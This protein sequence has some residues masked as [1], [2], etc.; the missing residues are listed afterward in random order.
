MLVNPAYIQNYINTQDINTILRTPANIWETSFGGLVVPAGWTMSLGGSATVNYGLELSGCAVVTVPP[1][2]TWRLYRNDFTLSGA[3]SFT[4]RCTWA[5]QTNYSYIFCE[6]ADSTEQNQYYGG[7]IHSNKVRLESSTRDSG[8]YKYGRQSLD[9][10]PDSRPGFNGWVYLHMQCNSSMGWFCGI[11]R[12]G[13]TWVRMTSPYTK[14]F[15]P[16]YLAIFGGNVDTCTQ[17][18]CLDWFRVN[19]IFI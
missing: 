12:D 19:W 10:S 6:L 11:S 2:Q 3:M 8:T 17:K 18:I 13:Y 16:S 15:T 14:S 4:L 9:L 5:G 1:N 7:L